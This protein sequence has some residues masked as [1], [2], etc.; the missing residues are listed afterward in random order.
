MSFDPAKAAELGRQARA[1]IAAN[2][3]LAEDQQVANFWAL[4][5]SGSMLPGGLE[6]HSVGWLLDYLASHDFNAIRLPLAADAILNP[7]CVFATPNAQANGS[8]ASAVE[9]NEAADDGIA[10]SGDEDTAS[11]SEDDDGAAGGA[12]VGAGSAQAR[13][14]DLAGPAAPAHR[15]VLRVHA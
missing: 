8:S 9:E 1:N 3:A 7:A 13:G 5:I 12:A 11:H 2:E 4:A 15:A 14:G 6:K 10:G